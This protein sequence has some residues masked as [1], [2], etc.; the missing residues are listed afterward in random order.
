MLFRSGVP[1]D[2]MVSKGYGE[3]KLILDPNGREIPEKSRRVVFVVTL[4]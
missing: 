2:D 1:A 4:A 3:T